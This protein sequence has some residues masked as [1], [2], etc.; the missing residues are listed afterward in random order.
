MVTKY[1]NVCN[2]DAHELQFI[3]PKFFW[4]CK[5]WI[6]TF[7][8]RNFSFSFLIT[9]FWF[10]LDS[11]FVLS[12]AGELFGVEMALLQ[13]ISYYCS[14]LFLKPIRYVKFILFVCFSC[15][16][17]RLT[18]RWNS[19]RTWKICYVFNFQLKKKS[20]RK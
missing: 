8:F 3:I 1:Q 14:L 4:T 6:G 5:F 18:K 20:D 12:S 11:R 15:H 17:R 2:L 19:R 16:I 7:S 10:M 9:L 13:G